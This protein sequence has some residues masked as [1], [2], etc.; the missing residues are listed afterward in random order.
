M[1]VSPV[2]IKAIITAAT[3][4]RTWKAV[5]VLITA[6]LMPIIIVILMVA[7]MFSG[8]ESA[9]K[10]LLDYSFLNAKIPAD[11]NG[12]QRAAIE[13]MREWLGELG[14]EISEK[15]NG[16][17]DENLVKAAFYCLNFGGEIDDDFDY[18][19]FC[20]CFENVKFKQL[21]TA[22]RKVSEEFPEYKISG[23]LSVSIKKVYDYLE[24]E[25]DDGGSW[26]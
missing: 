10:N 5:A 8:V 23:N 25:N 11:F 21:E 24:V 20:E 1:A 7:A 17:F 2:V 9:N 26:I 12:E 6:I 16:G 14:E 18:K 22:L 15:E 19:T 13:N 3:N 4:K